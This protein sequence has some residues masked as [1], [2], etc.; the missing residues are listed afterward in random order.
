LLGGGARHV[1]RDGLIIG[2][3]LLRSLASARQEQRQDQQMGCWTLHA[4]SGFHAS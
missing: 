2:I 1:G 3:D 4:Y